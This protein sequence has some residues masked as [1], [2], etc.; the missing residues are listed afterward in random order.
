MRRIP[1]ICCVFWSSLLEK[2]ALLRVLLITWMMQWDWSRD[3]W[4]DA[5]NVPSMP[6]VCSLD[7]FS[8]LSLQIFAN[9]L[10]LSCPFFLSVHQIWSLL[11]IWRSLLIWQAALLDIVFLLAGR[12]LIWTG[13]A[14]PAVSATTGEAATSRQQSVIWHKF[15]TKGVLI[16]V[17]LI[18]G[19]GLILL[20][21]DKQSD[22]QSALMNLFLWSKGK[23][24]L[25]IR[26]HT[27]HPLASCW[28]PRWSLPAKGVG[29]SNK[30]QWKN[31]TFGNTI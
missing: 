15:N 22:K 10:K 19:N 16:T 5:K 17:S 12:L 31:S 1:Q 14:Q 28:V 23:H 6:Q 27:F 3:L 9:R 29:P 4:K 18:L 24:S 21:N 7:G 2:V 13:F 8:E 20:L 30:N 26:Q 11:R 25:G